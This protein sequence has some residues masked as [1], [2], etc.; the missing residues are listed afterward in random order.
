MPPNKRQGASKVTP[1]TGGKYS[2]KKIRRV[3]FDRALDQ[4]SPSPENEVIT[5]ERPRFIPNSP[6]CSI[7]RSLRRSGDKPTCSLFGLHHEIMYN[8]IFFVLIVKAMT[9]MYPPFMVIE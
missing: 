5:R 3:I 7:I 4:Q 1:P 9:T 6:P 8:G 2:R